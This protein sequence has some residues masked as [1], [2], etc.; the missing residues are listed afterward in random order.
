[1]PRNTPAQNVRGYEQNGTGQRTP[2]MQFQPSPK[3]GGMTQQSSNS[4]MG[5]GAQVNRAGTAKGA[6][7]SSNQNQNPTAITFKQPDPS[8]TN[9]FQG[10]AQQQLAYQQNLN[11]K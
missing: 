8:S 9:G 10:T 6:Y 4:R 11:N 1:M 2:V 5:A 7:N 3:V